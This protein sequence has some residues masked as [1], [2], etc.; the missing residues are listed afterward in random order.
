MAV[1]FN[2]ARDGGR[3]WGVAHLPCDAAVEIRVAVAV[4]VKITVSSHSP[5]HQDYAFKPSSLQVKILN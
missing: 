2:A 3:R 1:I 4:A 5:S